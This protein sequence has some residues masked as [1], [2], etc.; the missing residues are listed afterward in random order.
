LGGGGEREEEES[1]IL[2]KKKKASLKHGGIGGTKLIWAM[3]TILLI[4]FRSLF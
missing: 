4:Q 2:V 1:M 3:N